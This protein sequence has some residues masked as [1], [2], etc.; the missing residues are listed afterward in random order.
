MEVLDQVVQGIQSA[1]A[2][3]N[4]VN[5]FLESRTLRSKVAQCFLLNG[6]IMAGS[7][8]FANQILF[9]ALLLLLPLNKNDQ[10]EL[11]AT[12]LI[13]SIVMGAFNLFW[14]YPIY[15]ISLVLNSVT[16]Q[17]I[18]SASFILHFKR[19]QQVQ[20]SYY[21]LIAQLSDL[22]YRVLL[23]FFYVLL[24]TIVFFIPI[25]GI[26]LSVVLVSWLYAFY[27][28]EYIWTM[29]SWPLDRQITF[30]EN[31]WAFFLGFGLPCS[32]LSHVFPV[33]LSAALCGLVFPMCVIMATISST[34]D[35]LPPSSPLPTRVPIFTPCRYMNLIVIWL[36]SK[37]YLRNDTQPTK[38][39][40]KT[41]TAATSTVAAPTPQ[42]KTV[43]FQEDT[44]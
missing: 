16:Y 15:T 32:I 33:V 37:L 22:I 14:L 12:S 8:L 44:K 43:R 42:T 6:G 18:A 39:L 41:P 29:Q 4:S 1:T 27:C 35:P 31:R 11:Q 28:F 38:P 19:Q 13:H 30:F 5:L 2:F 3:S 21:G 40:R 23:C 20:L 36:I 9:P 10:N 34:P 24:S 17:N 25:V 26:P 7:I